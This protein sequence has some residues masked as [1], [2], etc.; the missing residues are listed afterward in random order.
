VEAGQDRRR[1]G[2]R[3]GVVVAEARDLQLLAGR[4]VVDREADERLLPL[5]E[6]LPLA[7][8]DLGALR[9]LRHERRGELHARLLAEIA[10]HHDGVGGLPRR[11]VGG[12][13]RGAAGQGDGDQAGG[14][15]ERE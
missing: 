4:P 3:D 10:L 15:D 11:C 6:V 8:D 12:G 14:G 5:L 2:D 9:L 1:V 13:R 7:R